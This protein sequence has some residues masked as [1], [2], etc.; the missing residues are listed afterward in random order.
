MAANTS[1]YQVYIQ[2]FESIVRHLAQQEVTRLRPHVTER[3]AQSASH[4]WERLGVSSATQK[5]RRVAAGALVDTPDAGTPWSRRVSV[6]QTWH[7]GDSTEQED[8][9]QMLVDPNSNLA[10][11]L[12]YSMRRAMDDIIINAATGSALDG[13]GNNQTFPA[14]QLIDVNASSPI[15][16]DLI[17]QVQE[18]FLQRDITP[19]IPKVAI[20]GPTQV[21]KLMQ[22]TEQTSSDYVGVRGRGALQELASTGVA[23]NWMGFTWVMS[24]RLLGT[25]GTNIRCLFFTKRALGLHVARDINAR[26][27]EDPSKSFAWRIYCQFVAG[28]VRVED[29]HIVQLYCQ[30]TV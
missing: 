22:L 21:R 1:Q 11:S 18:K 30:D 8:P 14:Q 13:E 20:I 12:G 26:I 16:F 24:T 3:S 6:A 5:N 15:T 17:T 25:P 2:T 7:N 23:P 27:A 28:A 19:D 4:N 10:M 29:E 9:S